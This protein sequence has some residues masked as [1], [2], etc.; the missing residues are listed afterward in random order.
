MAIGE[1]LA[2]IIAALLLVLL[3]GFFVAAEFG[4][5]KLR[6]TRVRAMAK[7]LGWRGLILRRVHGNLDAY[8]SACQLGITLASL[9]L[10]WIGEPAF[11]RLL[12]PMFAAIGVVDM[13]F[14]HGVSFFIAFVTISF[15]HI[16][17]GE[18]APKSWAIRKPESAALW[19]ATPLYGFYWLMYPAIWLL[20]HSANALLRLIGLGS[21]GPH[22]THYSVDE[23]KLILRS[24]RADDQVT[25]N[26]WRMLAQALDF[27]DL[28]VADLL[29]PFAEA[30]SLL[31]NIPLAEN[32][33]R[34]AQH[35]FSR[36][37]LLNEEGRV[38]GIVHVKDLLIALHKNAQL[39]DLEEIAHPAPIINASMPATELFRRFQ[40]GAPHLAIANYKD[41]RPRGFLTLDNLLGPLVGEIRD[42][43]RRTTNEWIKLDDGSLMGKGSLPIFTLERT[44]G[45]DIESEHAETVAGLVLWK[46]GELPKEGERIAFDNFD[47]VVKKM[48][49]PRILLVRV[50]PHKDTSD[51]AI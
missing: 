11:A 12:E 35:R 8:L 33:E 29:R 46:L 30:T 25:G 19:T 16:V 40:K 31:Q 51:D 21:D 28:E 27:R 5:V 26:E 44:L 49:G 15:L 48:L 3:N 47:V 24:G 41:G 7:T 43:F 34:I 39:K 18:L 38:I 17:A 32:L 22:E 1:N 10:G 2:L 42:E 45:L 9:G 37:P 13:E 4:L 23:L 6:Q 50:Y 20:N 14:I 36:Y